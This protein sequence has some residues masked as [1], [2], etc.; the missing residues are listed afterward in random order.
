MSSASGLSAEHRAHA[1]R[2][3]AAGA[4]L[5][6]RHPREV[7][8]TQGGGRWEGIADRLLI[9]RGQYP[10]HGDCSST[11]T[12]LLWNA[13]AHLYGV[14]DVVNGTSW[15][16]GFTGTML[17]HGKPVRHE[18]NVKVG[19]LAIY[20]RGAPGEHVAVCLGGG[21]VFSHGSEAGPFKLP[22]HYRRDLLE[23]RRYV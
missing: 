18:A 23:I 1:R 3:V 15:R 17:T 21:V 7:H 4:E 12:W 11:A 9:A 20:G 6:L 8:Y 22:L 16:A 5:L 2:V 14:R 10:H 13:L 19:D